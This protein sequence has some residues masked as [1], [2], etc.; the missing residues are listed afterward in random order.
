LRALVDTVEAIARQAPTVMLF[1]DIHWVDPTTLETVDLLIHR[2]RNIPLLLV[3]THR[4]EFAPRW[5]NHGH[6]TALSLTKLTRPQSSA[7]VSQLTRGKALPADLLG[8]IL[9]KTDGVPL[10]IEELTK[11]I[12][13]SGALKDTGGHWEYSDAVGALAV[14]LTL[15]DSLMARLDRFASVKEIAQIGAV[16][17]RE[18]SYELLAAV[19]PHAQSERDRALAQ[20]IESGLAFQRG[21]P[22]DAAYTFKHA[23]VQDAAYD[24]L[25]KRRRH[26]LHAKIARVIQDQFPNVADTAPELLA[27]HN[28][29]ARQLEKAIPLWHK[30]GGLALKRMALAEAIAH[31]NKGLDLVSALPPSPE[32][33]SEELN[34]RTLLG[35]AW[36]ALKGWAAEEVWETLNPA[37]QL[38]KQLHRADALPTIFWILYC[39]VLTT[40]RVAETLSWVEQIFDAAETYH[41]EDLVIVG[42]FVATSSYF[43]HG[44]LIEAR[45]HA[46]QVLSLYE[47]RQH[48][49]LVGV[50]NH[51]PKTVALL[52]TAHLTWML[53]Y[54]EQ[55]VQLSDIKD[56]HARLLGHPFNLGFALTVGAR[57]FDHLGEPNEVMTRA[58]EVEQVG[59][60]NSMPVLTEILVPW[61]SGIA[62]IHNGQLVEGMASA[63]RGNAAWEIVGGRIN[64]PHIKSALAEAMAQLGDVDGALDLVEEC[65]AQIERPDWEERWNFANILRI[66]GTLLSAKGDLEGAESSYLASLDWARR[67]QAKSWELRAATSCAR[68]MRDQGR[69]REA[70]DLV[71]PIYGWF[72]EGFAT[73][74]LKEAKAL[75]DELSEGTSREATAA[76]VSVSDGS[77][78]SN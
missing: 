51:D 20:L 36:M 67:Q 70:Y 19:A 74:D 24:S 39:Y 14:P 64:V 61:H 18:F 65:I 12:L 37:L 69:I 71:A 66:K 25:L 62:M 78:A 57:M 3:I 59:R 73:K 50:L 16:I 41:N 13:E 40:G 32:R 4:P 6:V 15:R 9:A 30:A 28:T 43:W 60:E 55:A 42:H 77:S 29:E 63:K 45:E 33:D 8:Q 34:L 31:L 1:E 72:T 22:P 68:L 58:K 38:V 23:L 76:A 11:S 5:S 56:A 35:T 26:E 47:E 46:N 2:V 54:P 52:Y 10:F 49:H 44:D 17:G 53:G 27:H 7:L 21:T 75:L 48:G